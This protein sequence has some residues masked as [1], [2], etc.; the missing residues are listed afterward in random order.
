MAE[1]RLF[2]TD[3]M[4][5]A[6]RALLGGIGSLLCLTAG[7]ALAARPM[8]TDDARLVD[9][10]GCQLEGW[11]RRNADD[12]EIWA[13]PACNL[14]GNLE[15]TLGGALGR[16]DTGTH[17]NDVVF[18]GKTLFRPLEADSWGVGLAVGNVRHPAISTDRN[19]VGDLYA[20]VPISFALDQERQFLHVNL[21]WLHERDRHT[22]RATW[23]LGSE[24]R[25]SERTWLIAELYGQNGA[26][27][28][29]QVGL[30]YWLLPG[31]LQIDSTMGNRPGGPPDEH[32]LS[33]GL[34]LLSPPLLP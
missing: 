34:R 15:L 26:R 25:L 29:F 1:A 4:R 32:W 27:P 28:F 31:L 14:T 23:G 21:G 9:A 22:H 13:L 12:M 24:T 5:T 20:Y 6:L 11:V 10:G 19:L 8:V 17:T 3:E 30:R 16:D 18:Q 2:Q 33:L 7:N